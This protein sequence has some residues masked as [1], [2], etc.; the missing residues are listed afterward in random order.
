MCRSAQCEGCTKLYIVFVLWDSVSAWFW[1]RFYL[2]A[3]TWG[4]LCVLRLQKNAGENPWW[5]IKSY[6]SFHRPSD[7]RNVQCLC[8]IET[9]H[10]CAQ[11]HWKAS[12]PNFQAGLVYLKSLAHFPCCCW[13]PCQGGTKFQ[14]KIPTIFGVLLATLWIEAYSPFA[15]WAMEE[16][17]WPLG[18]NSGSSS[19]KPG[20][21]DLESEFGSFF[22]QVGGVSLHVAWNWRQRG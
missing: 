15:S 21:A 2:G 10:V 11:V 5:P 3:V 12:R 4:K 20:A 1:E 18:Q 9:R 19:L 6:C 7:L 16:V 22:P 17:L 14:G 8:I 13:I